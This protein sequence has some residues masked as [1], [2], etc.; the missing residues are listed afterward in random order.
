M[1]EIASFDFCHAT[2]NGAEF[3]LGEGGRW[4]LFLQKLS[5]S[6]TLVLSLPLLPLVIPFFVGFICCFSVDLLKAQALIL[7]DFCIPPIKNRFNCVTSSS[8]VEM[9]TNL[10][11]PV[12]FALPY[13]FTYLFIFIIFLPC[14]SPPKGGPMAMVYR[15]EQ[16]IMRLSKKK[17]SMVMSPAWLYP[18]AH[19][20]PLGHFQIYP[21][22]SVDM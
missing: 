21:G 22:H 3:L 6:H 13:L 1:G 5:H 9:P 11:A 7:V 17:V 19:G 14:P 20:T 16:M 12:P 18:K 4:R 10:S 2:V 8:K 15:H